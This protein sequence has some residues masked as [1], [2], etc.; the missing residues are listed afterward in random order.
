MHWNRK[1]FHKNSFLEYR[2]KTR[3][4]LNF[5]IASKKLSRK[6][7][8]GGTILGSMAGGQPDDELQNSEKNPIDTNHLEWI[9]CFTHTRFI[10]STC[11]ANLYRY[12]LN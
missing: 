7:R 5:I 12:G 4:S 6:D 1:Y 2:V 3:I 11:F 8:C 10:H 9:T